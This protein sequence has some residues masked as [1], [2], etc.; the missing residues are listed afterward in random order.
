MGKEADFADMILWTSHFSLLRRKPLAAFFNRP[1][2][3]AKAWGLL[4]HA[5]AVTVQPDKRDFSK[6]TLWF[7]CLKFPL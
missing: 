6:K 7:R 2:M 4:F 5:H 1:K 3:S